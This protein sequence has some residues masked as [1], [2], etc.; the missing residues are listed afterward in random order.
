MELERIL[1][2]SSPHILIQKQH[3]QRLQD[4]HRPTAIIVRA[5][6]A[7][8]LLSRTL[9]DIDEVDAIL[10]RTEHDRL[11]A[12]A[13]DD[14]NDGALLEAVLEGGCG[15]IDSTRY[16]QHVLHGLEQPC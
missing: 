8:C 4:R 15:G 5:R 10:M 2:P 9:F 14:R 12:Q 1:R 7:A 3:P 6:R 16:R 11:V 13:G